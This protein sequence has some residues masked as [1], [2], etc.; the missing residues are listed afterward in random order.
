MPLKPYSS[1]TVQDMTI[2]GRDEDGSSASR[3]RA[4]I[5]AAIPPLTSHD[6][7]P[8]SLPSRSEGVQGSMVMPSA[9]TV[10]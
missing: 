5:M 9:G 2:V 6:P 3:S 1:L 8:Y 10:S 4:V 7:R